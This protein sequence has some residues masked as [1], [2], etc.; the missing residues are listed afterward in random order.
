MRTPDWDEVREFLKHDL[1]APDTP[2]STDHDYFIKTLQDGEILITKV[3]RS[4]GR[5]MSA[6]RFKAILADQL[7]VNEAQ[8]CEVLRTKKPANRPAPE[9]E[10]EPVSLP[11][12]L[13]YELQRRGISAAAI[14]ML[15]ERT[16]TE[17][18]DRLRSGLL[19]LNLADADSL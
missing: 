13:A 4:G 12:W 17:V 11:L 16:S 9:P 19:A 10:P 2:R 3:S 15:D 18:L 6:G 1:W 5:T 14:G 8:F 7:R